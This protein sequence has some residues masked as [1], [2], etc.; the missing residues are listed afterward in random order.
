MHELQEVPNA[1]QEHRL[2]TLLL[3]RALRRHLAEQGRHTDSIRA[4]DEVREGRLGELSS[5]R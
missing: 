5:L 1:S 3:A 4:L 2:Q